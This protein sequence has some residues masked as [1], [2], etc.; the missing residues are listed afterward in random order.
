MSGN[1]RALEDTIEIVRSS[2][3]EKSNDIKRPA[4]W[5]YRKS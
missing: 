3:V 1:H 5:Q 4:S 2:I